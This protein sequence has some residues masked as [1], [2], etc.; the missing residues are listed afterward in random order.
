M[1]LPTSFACSLLAGAN[2]MTT[3]SNPESNAK[4]KPVDTSQPPLND[5]KWLDWYRQLQNDRVRR[6]L[7]LTR[8][9]E[10]VMDTVDRL[11]LMEERGLGPPEPITVDSVRERMGLKP[12]DPKTRKELWLEDH[13]SE[14]G[15]KE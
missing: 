12:L 4:K 5:P 3:E 8:A 9:D 13:D 10:G 15:N 6:N 11:E 7:G 1:A 14:K 2:R